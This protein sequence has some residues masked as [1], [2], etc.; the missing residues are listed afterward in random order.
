MNFLEYHS[1]NTK[2]S[3]YLELKVNAKFYRNA[4]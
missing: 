2:I 1:L 4:T 3:S